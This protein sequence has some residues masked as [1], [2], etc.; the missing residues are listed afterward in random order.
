MKYIAAF[1]LLFWTFP[2]Y[3]ANWGGV[4][5]TLCQT[6]AGCPATPTPQATPTPAPNNTG[7]WRANDFLDSIGAGTKIIQARSSVQATINAIKY[8]GIRHFRDDASAFLST[9][10]FGGNYGDIC[11]IHA[12][13]PFA[14]WH[15][16]GIAASWSDPNDIAY[17]MTTYKF[18][19]SCGALDSFVEGMNEMNNNG[20]TYL[21]QSCGGSGGSYL[22]CL[23]FE[24]DLYAA[25]KNDGADPN[26][27]CTGPGQTIMTQQNGGTLA[28]CTGLDTGTCPSVAS[29]SF[30]GN[31]TPGDEPD[32]VSLQFLTV[33][34]V[35][36]PNG[37]VSG[38]CPPTGTRLADYANYHNYV[39]ASFGPGQNMNLD[40]QSRYATTLQRVGVPGTAGAWDFWGEYQGGCATNNNSDSGTYAHNFPICLT[41][42]NAVPKVT[43]EDGGSYFDSHASTFGVAYASLYGKVTVVNW[44]DQYQ[45]GFTRTW[46]YLLINDPCE[47][48]YGFF[49]PKATGTNPN[50]C[51]NIGWTS[52]EM[53]AG[54]A[55]PLGIY[56]HNIFTILADNSS[57]F[58]PTNLPSLTVGTN[59]CP[60]DNTIPGTFPHTCYSQLMEKS[61]GTYELAIWGESWSAETTTSV[62]VNLG[63]AYST[64]SV[65]DP[66]LAS[67]PQQTFSN[68]QNL[69]VQINDHPIFVEFH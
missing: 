27:Y 21:G 37:A 11:S 25:I 31:V 61:N 35:C 67:T 42:Q 23:K 12:A 20:Y 48:G 6:S 22:P 45:Q 15:Q 59:S 65:Y 34:S 9:N 49:D 26:K 57:N 39:Q 62:A 33:N 3:A 60:A 46:D 56:A 30:M 47:G 1:F 13:V 44:F 41:T 68:T 36:Q 69:S 18:L 28:C 63:A 64:V 52:D 54:T 53:D 19:K 58:T 32:N 29:E 7:V 55:T 4:S 16:L 43:T 8:T 40:D 2:A 66:T 24:A 51:S 38:T 14:T 50:N 5:V 17:N 10:Q